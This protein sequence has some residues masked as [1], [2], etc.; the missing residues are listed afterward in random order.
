MGV[1]EATHVASGNRRKVSETSLKRSCSWAQSIHRFGNMQM[2][3]THTPGRATSKRQ[4]IWFYMRNN[5][6]PSTRLPRF[7]NMATH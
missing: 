2:A 1:T 7:S 6:H 4:N 3:W 5:V